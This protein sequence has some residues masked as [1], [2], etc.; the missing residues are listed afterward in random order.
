MKRSN[1][2]NVSTF[3]SGIFIGIFIGIFLIII[4]IGL[5]QGHE[6]LIDVE[7]L[8]YV[9]EDRYGPEYSFKKVISNK[10]FCENVSEVEFISRN[11]GEH[12]ERDINKGSKERLHSTVRK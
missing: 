3:V 11:G 10:L 5:S 7:I 9:C 1:D 4:A 6:Y 12:Y 2:N 8:D